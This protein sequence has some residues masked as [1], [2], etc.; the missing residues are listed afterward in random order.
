MNL[1]ERAKNIVLSPNT[2]W[3][4]IATDPT[5]TPKLITGYSKRCVVIRTCAA[6]KSI[7]K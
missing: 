1:I 5:P 3:D 6:Y 2:E 7:S 4:A